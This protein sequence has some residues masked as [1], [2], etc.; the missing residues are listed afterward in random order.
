M[1]TP[2]KYISVFTGQEIDQAIAEMR[3]ALSASLIV[4]DFSGGTQKVASA[5][6]AKILKG[7]VDA[8][9]LPANI[10]TQLLSNANTHVLTDAEYSKINYLTR[11]TS[12]RGVFTNAA[13]RT[14][15]LSSEYTGYTGNEVTFIQDDGSG[16]GLSEFSRWDTTTSSWAKIRLYNTGG[17]TPTTI[18]SAGPNN[19][20]S[21]RKD[22]YNTMKVLVSVSN[23][24]G[25]QRQIQEAIVTVIGSD[26]Y[27]SVYNEVGNVSNLY[28]LSSSISGNNVNLVVTTTLPN[29]VVTGRVLAMI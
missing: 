10:K 7:M 28:S 26:T 17:T 5:E 8:N 1:A 2:Q 9:N 27:I 25:S 12:F 24:V 15:A 13:E 23:S 4:N 21:F 3:G 19:L 18:V 20:F 6:L 29:L 14:A 16:D 11:S 22:R